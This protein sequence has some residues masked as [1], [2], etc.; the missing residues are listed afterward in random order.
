MD[1]ISIR[2]NLIM[3]N[4]IF[5]DVEYANSKTK[6]ICQIGIICEDFSTGDSNHPKLNI[7]VNPEDAF[8]P[9]CIG[10]H[11]I[12]SDKVKNAPNFPSVW[13][14]IEK[15]F[16]KS[17]IIGHNVSD[18]DLDVLVKNLKRYNLDI[19]E[20]YY[21]S[22]MDLAKKHIPSYCV[23]DYSLATL[24]K[25]FD[26][27]I[28]TEHNAFDDAYACSELFKAIL[29]E[30]NITPTPVK[31][32][33]KDLKQH[34]TY[35]DEAIIRK[36]ISEFYG[37]I[38]GIAIDN[39]INEGELEIISDWKNKNQKY[40]DHLTVSSIIDLIN[41]VLADGILTEVEVKEIEKTISAYLEEASTSRVTLA[42]QVLNGILKGITA[43]GKIS[44]NE[45]RSLHR[46]LY[47]NSFLSEH[48]AFNKTLSIVDKIIKDSIV[49]P[50]EL[51]NLTSTVAELLNPIEA[52]K[53]QQESQ[54]K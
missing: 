54:N 21:I 2:R 1:V 16:T 5:F 4:V 34:Y 45:C 22:L 11:G 27:E 18:Y 49:T 13:A 41:I 50:E 43:D 29:N 52:I 7:Y 44:E 46:W 19:P 36:S 24:C 33:L 10:I 15:H 3:T 47:E 32:K 23:P 30:Y 42:T 12:T 20:F 51:A 53:K 17:V 6:S 31:Y 37:I 38:R 35:S 14:D 25:Y 40:D 26:I 8:E 39:E 48:F 28:G 9:G